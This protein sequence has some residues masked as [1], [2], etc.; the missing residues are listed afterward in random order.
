MTAWLNSWQ[1]GHLT[2]F[3]VANACETI[4]GSLDV[5]IRG[6]RHPWVELL[7]LHGPISSPFR[8]ALPSPGNPDGIPLDV[9]TNFETTH[10]L[11][12]MGNHLVI[13]TSPDSTWQSAEVELSTI[14]YDLQDA[15][16][17]MLEALQN[18]QD[19]LSHLDLIGSRATADDT[20][21]DLS[22]GQLPPSTPKR[23]IDAIDL[24][25]RITTL[26]SIAK[27]ESAAPSSRSQDHERIR[28]LT[29][30]EKSAQYLLQAAVSSVH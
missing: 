25:F 29:E 15:R 16:I 13:G 27:D 21:K 17:S 1:S 18:A 24:A 26:A 28:I 12:V 20:L 2:A 22:F 11:I 7:A 10:G 5:T 9:L 23:T 8:V 14:Q 30:L 4:S 19:S 3:D 6:T